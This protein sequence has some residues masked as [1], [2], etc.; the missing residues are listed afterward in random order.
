MFLFHHCLI[1]INYIMTH[2]IPP[3]TENFVSIRRINDTPIIIN[4]VNHDNLISNTDW[5][6]NGSLN[7]E[8]DDQFLDN[9]NPSIILSIYDE[10]YRRSINNQPILQYNPNILR[11]QISYPLVNFSIDCLQR[12]FNN[13]SI[14]ASAFGSSSGGMTSH[15]IL[16][17]YDN[18]YVAYVSASHGPYLIERVDRSFI[19]TISPF[20]SFN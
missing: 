20:H 19:N 8:N 15:C 3:N 10:I 4:R 11:P 1:P 13:P 16:R 18:I 14:I 5:T 2:I 7:N 12:F 17:I 6:S 9:I